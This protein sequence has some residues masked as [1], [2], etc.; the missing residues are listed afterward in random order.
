MK[1]H[2]LCDGPDDIYNNFTFANAVCDICRRD[3]VSLDL[4]V[5]IGMLQAQYMHDLRKEEQR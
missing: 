1:L 2:I 3:C 4:G 5:I